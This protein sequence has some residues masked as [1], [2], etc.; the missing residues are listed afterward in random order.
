MNLADA[1]ETILTNMAIELEAAISNVAEFIACDD[2][3]IVF[4]FDFEMFEL[5]RASLATTFARDTARAD[6]R[7]AYRMGACHGR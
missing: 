6:R 1:L 2:T 3:S 7:D 4:D 5:P